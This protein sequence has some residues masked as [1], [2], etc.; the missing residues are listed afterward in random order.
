[1][2]E[3]I[4]QLEG[5][6]RAYMLKRGEVWQERGNIRQAIDAYF[7]VVECFPGTDEARQAERQLVVSGQHFEEKRKVHSAVHLYSRL[8]G[9]PYKPA[10]QN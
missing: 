2:V 10:G 3:W 8:A 7:K 1:M 9:F 5:M 6:A 4:D